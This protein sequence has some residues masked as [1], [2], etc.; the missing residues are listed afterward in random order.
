MYMF[1]IYTHTHTYV[2]LCVCM[3]LPYLDF[4]LCE[5]TKNIKKNSKICGPLR[6]EHLR[7][8]KKLNK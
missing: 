7:K 5:T 4:S 6:V 1:Y 8:E 2:C 3:P